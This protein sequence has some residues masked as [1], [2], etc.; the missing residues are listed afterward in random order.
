MPRTLALV[1]AAVP[2]AGSQPSSASAP[3]GPPPLDLPAWPPRMA[4]PS[5]WPLSEGSAPI[6]PGLRPVQP[7]WEGS[8]EAGLAWSGP[9]FPPG[10]PLW[11]ALDQQMLQE[12][13]LCRAL[14]GCWPLRLLPIPGGPAELP[15]A[16]PAG[17]R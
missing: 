1:V 9:G 5:L 7:L 12:G 16:H 17:V 2:V 4:S 3:P 6:L 15:V 14:A 10:T 13:V 8:S 11:A